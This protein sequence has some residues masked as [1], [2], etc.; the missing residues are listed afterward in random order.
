MKVLISAL[1]LTAEDLEVT[2]SEQLHFDQESKQFW[3][4]CVA[5]DDWFQRVTS[6]LPFKPRLVRYS[7]DAVFV[8]FDAR[9]EA[10]A[11]CAWL[12]EAQEAV[13]HGFATMR[14]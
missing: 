6:N 12:H 4:R 1:E 8:V 14:G 9:S 3:L 5:G 7:E 13:R 10:I 2:V 11:L